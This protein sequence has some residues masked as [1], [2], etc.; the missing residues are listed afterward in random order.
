MPGITIASFLSGARKVP[1]YGQL[2][3]ITLRH[4]SRLL[5]S[6]RKQK[7]SLRI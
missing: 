5:A 7:L 3:L 1:T 6:G 4:G 2:A